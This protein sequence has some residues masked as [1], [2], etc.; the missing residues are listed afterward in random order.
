MLSTSDPRAV[1]LLV[2]DESL[3]L[4][5]YSR[6]LKGCNVDLVVASR[7]QEALRVF[8]EKAVDVVIA[9]YRMPD[10]RGDELLEKIHERWPGTVRILNTAFAEPEVIEGAVRRG[11]IFRF[12]TKP[13]TP[14]KLR[15]TVSDA[16]EQ[17]RRLKE[18]KRQ[19]RKVELDL[20]SFREI[21]DGALDPMMVADLDG[22]LVEVNQAFVGAFGGGRDLAL[23]RR[24][25][26]LAASD[27]ETLWPVI[28]A[29][30]LEG[31]SWCDEVWFRGANGG[32]GEDRCVLMT[33]SAVRDR[34]RLGDG[35]GAGGA[36]R[37]ARPYALAAVEK[38]VTSRRR[39]EEQARAA[40]YEVILSLA[41]LAEFR[42]TDTGAHLD[43]ISRYSA[44][45]AEG[46]R[47]C[48]AYAR[49]IDDAYVAAVFASSPLHD[50]G[51]VGI[52]DAVLL[53]PGPLDAAE[54]K[55]MS[56]HSRIGAE[57]LSATGRSLSQKD[58]LVMA[59]TIALQHHE[60]FDGGGTPFGL[61]G[62]QIDLAAR[63][64]A[65][66][67]AYDA[68][69]SRRV[70]KPAYSHAVAKQRILESRGTHFDPDV[71]QAFLDAE[72]RLLAIRR[73]FPDGASLEEP[74]EDKTVE[75]KTVE[76]P[77]SMF[78]RIERLLARQGP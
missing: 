48:P 52:P 41:K 44:L 58:W 77:A 74:V 38:D 49:V 67:D 55:V 12:L 2:D 36:A 11:A 66:A 75:D 70:Y 1:V 54:W 42:D 29:L 21:F 53:K 20:Q 8:E 31:G 71:V 62:T 28:R 64:V 25:T 7:P 46:L 57:V 51:K 32:A 34:G 72:E 9:D 30:V 5:S 56:L 16:V 17:S 63:I 76:D 24:P 61:G 23:E 43:R 59:R 22:N 40:Q 47:S 60:R 19:S 78:M 3:I 26:I 10:M 6:M 33:I 14:D 39:L 18:Q 4:S 37:E 15:L 45:I 27:R 73:E 65:L 68:I 50:I 13:I 35:A 69:T